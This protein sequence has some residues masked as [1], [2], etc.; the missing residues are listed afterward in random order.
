MYQ[1]EITFQVK[2][3]YHHHQPINVPTAGAH[4]F[5][6]DGIGRLDPPRVPSVHCTSSTVAPVLQKQLKGLMMCTALGRKRK[7]G[8]FLVSTFSFRNFDLQNQPPGRPVSK[9]GYCGSESITKHFRDSCSLQDIYCQ[10]LQIMKEE[11]AAKQPRL[12]N[13]SRPLLR[14]GNARPHTAQQTTTKLDELQL[15]WLRHPPS[16]PDL[17]PIDYHFFRNLDN[18]LQATEEDTNFIIG[19]L[20]KRDTIPLNRNHRRLGNSIEHSLRYRK[21]RDIREDRRYEI[22]EKL[23]R[24]MK[25]EN[26]E[27]L[28]KLHREMRWLTID[29]DEGIGIGI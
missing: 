21:T 29:T 25:L 27:A 16:S 10:Q 15:E 19:N 5:P 23:L 11:L 2:K 8:T 17:A 24:Q 3:P 12:V 4:A 14:H 6:V 22:T 20:R 18:F 7:H 26:K 28:D 9:V 13:R 1:S